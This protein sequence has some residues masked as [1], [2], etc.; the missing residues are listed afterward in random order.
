MGLP[1]ISSD[2]APSNSGVVIT[3]KEIS[4]VITGNYPPFSFPPSESRA[5]APRRGDSRRS[6]A[7]TPPAT[8]TPRKEGSIDFRE[9][10]SLEH[11][12]GKTLLGGF[13]Y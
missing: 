9:K 8:S 7:T 6:T 11:P 4:P 12:S 3:G 1:D 13:K 5:N 10:A 2:V